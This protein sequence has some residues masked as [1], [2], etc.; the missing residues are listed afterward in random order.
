[1]TSPETNNPYRFRIEP[2][3]PH[4]ERASFSCGVPALDTYLHQRAGQDVRRF[5]AAPFVLCEGEAATV[6]GYYTLS[7]LSIDL[8]AFP[9]QTA[10]KFGRY[11]EIPAILIGRFAVDQRWHGHRLGQRLL[12]NALRRSW[13]QTTEIA[14]AAVIV[15]SKNPGTSEFYKR[16]GFQAFD[17]QPNRLF[18]PMKTIAQ[19]IQR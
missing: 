18:I 12:L 13:R 11:P 9:E 2:L 6:L 10:R 8:E 1:M 15:D 14:A 4:H 16:H 3:G 17:D 19:L 5:V 7:S